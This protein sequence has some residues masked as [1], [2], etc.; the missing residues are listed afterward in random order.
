[1]ERLNFCSLGSDKVIYSEV[2]SR[3]VKL[4]YVWVLAVLHY[5]NSH[6]LN[7]KRLSSAELKSDKSGLVWLTIYG[8]D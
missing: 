3:Y 4:W 6:R 5:T 2:K 8:L 1:M 7:D